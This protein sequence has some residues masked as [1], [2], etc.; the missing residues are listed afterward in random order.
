MLAKYGKR[1]QSGMNCNSGR[2][3]IYVDMRGGGSWAQ[4]RKSTR[5]QKLQSKKY[6]IR[7]ILTTHGFG[8][9]LSNLPPLTPPPLQSPAR[10]ATG[11]PEIMLFLF[12]D[13][14]G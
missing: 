4:T 1:F 5:R 14:L 10:S 13:T 6:I 12:P 2:G 7:C 9:F 8:L 3:N 11:S